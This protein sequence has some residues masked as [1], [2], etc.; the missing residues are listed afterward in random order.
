MTDD[1]FQVMIFI[2][3]IPK[4]PLRWPLGANHAVAIL[5]AIK[6]VD[7]YFTVLIF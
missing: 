6:V 3:Y 7:L 2:S 5:C 1:L 4:L